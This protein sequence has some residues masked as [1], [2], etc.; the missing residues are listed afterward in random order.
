MRH[1]VKIVIADDHP[2]FRKGLVEVLQSE[3]SFHVITEVADGTEALDAIERFKP[4]IAILDIEMPKMNGLEL[5][6]EITRRK[7]EVRVIVLTM[8]EEEKMLNRRWI[9]ACA[10]MYL[11][12]A[13]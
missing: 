13:P 5:L 10:D 4:D 6:K 8:Y 9:L 7:L 11:K 3:P 1:E 2:I 12:R